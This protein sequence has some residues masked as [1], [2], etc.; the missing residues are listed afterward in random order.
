VI[1]TFPPLQAA[2]NYAEPLF[3]TSS[4]IDSGDKIDAYVNRIYPIEYENIPGAPPINNAQQY[5]LS[6]P[7]TGQDW[8]IIELGTP[9]AVNYITMDVLQV[10]LQIDIFYDTY[11]DVTPMNFVQVTPILPYT[12]VL[13]NSTT[14]T[15]IASMAL[16]FSNSLQQMV[17]TR[18]IQILF[19]RLNGYAGI[20]QVANLRLGRNVSS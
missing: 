10:P 3:V 19:S 17:Y 15:A 6:Q 14:G 2:A 1:Q 8:L 7:S 9:Q 5:W 18:R 4:E 12:N 16:T 13:A 11:D 20:V